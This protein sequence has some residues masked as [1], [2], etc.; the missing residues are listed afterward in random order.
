MTGPSG[1]LRGRFV[2]L[3]SNK[4]VLRFT[5]KH[6]N[7]APGDAPFDALYFATGP[8]IPRAAAALE[9]FLLGRA[10]NLDFTDLIIESP[11][12]LF[13]S[14]PSLADAFAGL[15]GL[16]HL[17]LLGVGQHSRR[18]LRAMHAQLSSV[19]LVMVPIVEDVG[20]G[21]EGWEA[22]GRNPITLLENFQ[23]TL[24]SLTGEGMET[25]CVA[26]LAYP[27]HYPKVDQVTLEGVDLPIATHY[28]QAFPNLSSLTLRTETEAFVE[29]LT[30]G[31]KELHDRRG[32]NII[33]QLAH[34][35]W[36]SLDF[37]DTTLGTL[38]VLGL[39]CHVRDLRIRPDIMG[40]AEMLGRVLMDTRP[41]LLALHQFSLGMLSTPGF[42]S[43]MGG[44][45]V[46]QVKTL[47]ITLVLDQK[48]GKDKAIGAAFD[49]MIAALKPLEIQSL[50]L[51]LVC[52]FPGPLP[53]EC[54]NPAVQVSLSP[55]ETFLKDLGLETLAG[56]LRTAVGSLPNVVVL[57][58]GH[59]TRAPAAVAVGDVRKNAELRTY[60]MAEM[61]R[62]LPGVAAGRT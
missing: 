53:R 18:L 23:D 40:P 51:M 15:S 46:R 33:E 36:Q 25:L 57:I 10:R 49:A 58:Y 9:A 44:P 50:G 7:A 17:E 60:K 28:I 62:L 24:E 14:C 61:Y 35:S 11:E 56:R 8:L 59:R 41:T 45:A 12:K 4:D 55:E 30:D 20:E 52:N 42:A 29:L 32:L 26:E 22:T 5:A 48:S 27:Q 47:E 19:A 13:E 37:C 3:R 54:A 31:A 2:K 38:Y 43:I 1:G 16:T 21:E 6:A 39:Q 34:G